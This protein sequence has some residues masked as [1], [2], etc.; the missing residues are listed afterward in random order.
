MPN[1]DQTSSNL[2][3]VD[4]DGNAISQSNPLTLEDILVRIHEENDP[5]KGSNT[6]ALTSSADSPVGWA[7]LGLY[8]RDIFLDGRVDSVQTALATLQTMFDNLSIPGAVPDA[9][10]TTKG[11]AEI[12]NQSEGRGGTDAERIMTALRV[13]DLIRN[14]SGVGATTTRRGTAEV[15]TQGE[16]DAGSNN[17]KFVTPATLDDRLDDFPESSDIDTMT[18]LTQSAFD[19]LTPNARTLYAIVG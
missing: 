1:L 11:I 5:V 9:S 8:L 7:L 19:A 12:A 3:T 6:T 15:A 18:E 13:L 2:P 17:D 16:V 4:K 10:T 14:G